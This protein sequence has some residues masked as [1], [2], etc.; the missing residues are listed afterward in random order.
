MRSLVAVACV[1]ALGSA[2]VA[3]AQSVTSGSAS[4]KKAETSKANSRTASGTVKSA[5]Q[6][7]VVVAGRHKGKDTEWTFAVEPTT[8][9][10][11]GGKSIVAGD[12]KSGDSVQV[13]FTEQGGKAMATSILVKGTTGTAKKP[14]P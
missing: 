6:E 10:R 3:S 1:I 9:I 12:L 13:R 8:N 5:S 4:T 7:T 11:K 14:K 2:G